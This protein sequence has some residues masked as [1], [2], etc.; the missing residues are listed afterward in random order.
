VCEDFTSLV[1]DIVTELKLMRIVRR[2]NESFCAAAVTGLVQKQFSYFVI[3]DY[4]L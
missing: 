4:S 1:H 3:T 2:Q